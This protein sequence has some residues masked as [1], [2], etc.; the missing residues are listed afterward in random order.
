MIVRTLGIHAFM[1]NKGFA[2]FNMRKGMTTVWAFERILLVKSVFF[3][4]KCHLA[5]LTEDLTLRTIIFIQIWHRSTA[6]R[7]LA[8]LWYIAP[9]ASLN[10]LNFAT[11]A[12][13]VVFLK[14]IPVPILFVLEDGRKFICFELLVLWG[15]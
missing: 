6:T 12:H 8:F 2:V 9:L 4:R 1:Q 7:T 15:M 3:W 10:R 14:I 13:K 5:N 11:I